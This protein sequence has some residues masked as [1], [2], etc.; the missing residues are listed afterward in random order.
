MHLLFAR[1]ACRGTWAPASTAFLRRRRISS[2]SSMLAD[3]GVV[4]LLSIF[5]EGGRARVG[6]NLLQPEL[7]PMFLSLSL[8]WLCPDES[9]WC[10]CGACTPRNICVLSRRQ[11]A[12]APPASLLERYRWAK[13][14]RYQCKLPVQN[15]CRVDCCLKPQTYAPT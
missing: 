12:E 5:D 10:V 7:T 3:I 2:R 1:R 15:L 9:P 6:C 8:L 4:V 14:V 13:C 11:P